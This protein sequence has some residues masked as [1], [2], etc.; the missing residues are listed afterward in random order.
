MSL[1]LFLF[2][3]FISTLAIILFL[4]YYDYR[5]KWH[6]KTRPFI[7]FLIPTLNDGA[8]LEKTIESIYG[9]Y[10][11]KSFEVI[12]VNDGSTDNTGSLLMQLKKEYGFS[13][14][15]HKKNRGKVSSLNEAFEKSKGEII[16]FVDSDLLVSKEAIEEIIARMEDPKVGAASCRYR[17]LNKGIWAKM[18]AIEFGMM[19]SIQTAYNPFTTLSLWGG[20]MAVKRRAFIEVKKLSTNAICEDMD[21]ALKL[22]ERGWK[23]QEC[24]QAVYM[25]VP[26]S[27]KG[28]FKQRIRTHEGGMQNY[29]KHYKYFLRHPLYIF[30][31]LTYSILTLVFVQSL[32]TQIVSLQNFYVFF[33]SFHDAGYSIVSSFSLAQIAEGI[34]IMKIVS[35]SLA[36]PLFSSHYVI[37]NVKD[38]KKKPQTLLWVFPYAIIYYPI[39]AIVTVIGLMLG[40]YKFFKLKEESR[41]W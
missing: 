13:V 25:Y 26:D 1:N 16:F 32:L 34:E 41:G 17:P 30:F 31:T 7:S 10:D 29:L 4:L 14:I 18:Q 20:C 21:L 2:L 19:S 3:I 27:L 24:K 9:S 5:K 28:W 15:T 8:S 11:K 12:V 37:I 22:G 35:V 33:R 6:P 39:Y 23:V 36:Y 40:V 38:F